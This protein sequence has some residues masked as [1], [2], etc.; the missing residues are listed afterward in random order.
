MLADSLA[1]AIR[2]S[3]LYGE[4]AKTKRSLEQMVRS[5]N[6][7]IISIDRRGSITRWN[8]VAE[9]ISGWNARE[10]IGRSLVGMFP[11]QYEQAAR[12]ALNSV[13]RATSCGHRAESTLPSRR[14]RV[15][16]G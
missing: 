10:A 13:R 4:V 3:R 9:R 14:P 2:N 7:A 6:D 15:S 5:A 1:V 12:H 16:P 11:A 8:P